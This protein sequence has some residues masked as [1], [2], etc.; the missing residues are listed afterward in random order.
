M[1][2]R[3]LL[4]GNN[5]APEPTG[6]GK[7][8]GEMIQ[9]LT[10]H[11][12][13]CTV[14]AA[15]PYYPQWKVQAPYI[16][17]RFWYK[18]E[19]SADGRITIYRCPQYVPCTPSGKKRM[20]MDI[21][22]AIATFFRLLLLLPRK[23]FDVV[24]TVAPPFYLGLLGVLYKKIR[25][26]RLV[27]HIQDLQIEAARDLNM[28][29]SATLIRLFFRIEKYILQQAD[30][31]SSISS[32]MMQKIAKKAGRDIT[33][34]P[35]W[36]DISLFY[37]VKDKASLKKGFGFTPADKVVLYAGAIGEKQGLEAILQA[38]VH[39]R[40]DPHLKFVI[41]GSGPYKE[42]LAAVAES[43]QLQQVVFMPTQPSAQFNNFLNMADV[44]LIIQK[45]NAGDLVMPSKL[46]TIMA[47]GGVAVI[48]A[49]PGTSLYELVKEQQMGILVPAEDQQ[50]LNE[51][52]YTAI[53]KESGHI[54]GN[55]REY[56]LNYLSIDKIMSRFES[57]LR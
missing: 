46:T 13:D 15:Y 31:V 17:S 38:A 14:I 24:I 52:I 56:A 21:S 18:K 8:S 7:Y 16:K 53:Y 27:Y 40:H 9:W 1:P 6:I 30:H 48:T 42:K 36:A 44:H 11:G 32:G 19:R 12:Y 50:A 4:F 47:V 43:L 25:K 20:L 51:G 5:Y 39:Y 45:A 23:K 22:F 35:N 37:P 26:A 49:N 29:R 57:C 10:N 2:G 54:P 33:F 41:C 28:I 55:A 3:I 34:F